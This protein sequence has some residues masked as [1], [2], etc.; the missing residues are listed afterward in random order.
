MFKSGQALLVVLLMLGVALTIGISIASRSTTE[1][2]ISTT[3]QEAAR[4]LEA[5]ET[6]IEKALGGVVVGNVV[7]QPVDTNPIDT[8][9]VNVQ[10]VAGLQQLVS[11]TYLVGGDIATF[12]IEDI[13]STVGPGTPTP[14]PN[15]GPGGPN[16]RVRVCWG[17]AGVSSAVEVSLLSR[18]NPNPK[19]YFVRR[20][21]YDPDGSRRGSNNFMAPPVA[22]PNPTM[23]PRPD[24]GGSFRYY[25]EPVIGKVATKPLYLQVRTLYNGETPQQVGVSTVNGSPCGGAG[26][27]WF[28]PMQGKTITA[29]G[30]AGQVTK[31]LQVT[32]SFADPWPIFADVIFPGSGS[33]GHSN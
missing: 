3:Q 5:A 4:A 2:E 14:T 16:A 33:V 22:T 10:T 11:R 32:E 27:C 24:S 28:F 7:D 9:S 20:W 12:N 1:V 17:E 15:E 26:W 13:P 18:Q 6:G 19:D 29:V 21:A 31:R 30:V 23:C 8:Y 25:A